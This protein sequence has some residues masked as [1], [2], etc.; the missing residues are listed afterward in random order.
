[1]VPVIVLG[2]KEDMAKLAR[3]RQAHGQTAPGKTLVANLPQASE[4]KTRD[5][6][7]DMAGVSH[8]TLDKVERIERE[9]IPAVRK[10]AQIAPVSFLRPTLVLQGKAGSSGKR[11]KSL[12]LLVPRG[13]IEPPTRGFSV[14]CST[15]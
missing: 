11:R 13:G 9:A 2:L 10:L 5:V 6:L 3:E 7:A 15:D 1:M 8:G 12:I 4:P 14:L